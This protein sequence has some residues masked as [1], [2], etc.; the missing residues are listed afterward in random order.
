MGKKRVLAVK[1]RG[2]KGLHQQAFAYLAGLE[3]EGIALGLSRI[4]RFLRV[5]GN[6]EK[7]FHVVHVAGTNGKGSTAATVSYTHLTL[8]TN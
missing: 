2:K 1:G 6:P 5:L 7:R 3:K 4:R 8:P